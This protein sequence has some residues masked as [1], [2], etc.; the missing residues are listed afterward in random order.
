MTE[1]K[2]DE[3]DVFSQQSKVLQGDQIVLINAA[4]RNHG[5]GAR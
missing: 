5:S 2:S 1:H 3:S 4:G